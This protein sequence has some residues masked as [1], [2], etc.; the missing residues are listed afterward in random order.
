MTLEDSSTPTRPRV[1]IAD[2]HIALADVFR[3]LLEESCDV[4]GIA[5]DG[6]E[7]L[8]EVARLTPDVVVLDI[9][10]P[11][12]NGSDAARQIRKSFPDSKIVFLTMLAEAHLAAAVLDWG[13][14][15]YVLKSSAASE[16]LTAVFEVFEGRSYITHRLRARN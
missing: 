12:L 13:Q 6:R 1:L 14:T 9:S 5:G 10:M 7:L 16:L 3:A 4:V 15:G 8:M 2:D 11:K